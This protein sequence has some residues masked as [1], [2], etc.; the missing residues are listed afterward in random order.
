M[1][2]TAGPFGDYISMRG[3][4]TVV[5]GRDPLKSYDKDHGWYEHAPGTV[6]FKASDAEF[7]GDGINVKE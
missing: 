3:M 4:M 7:T 5:K 6:A 1:K 2:G